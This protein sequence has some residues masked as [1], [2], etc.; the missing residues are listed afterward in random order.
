MIHLDFINYI[1]S[2]FLL[3]TLIASGGM[4]IK[5]NPVHAV[6][7]LIVAYFGGAVLMLINNAEFLA[8]IVL[9]VYV[10]AV[11]VLFLFVVMMID[12]DEIKFTKNTLLERLSIIS[13][14]CLLFGM[15]YFAMSE[16][17]IAKQDNIKIAT[18]NSMNSDTKSM[19][20]SQ[21][22]VF[23]QLIYNEENSIIL[24][25]ASMI[26]FVAVVGVITLT[27]REKVGLKKQNLFTQLLRSRED[28]LEVKKV[29]IGAG[30]DDE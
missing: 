8:F 7:C 21:A 19:N 20:V 2:F 18:Q 14:G 3:V 6:L 22:K 27:L 25:V 30:V 23:G 5:N 10:G 4:V 9:T 1:I 12:V 24:I 13:V 15:L 16:E 17:V 26:L 28:T 11:M 29:L